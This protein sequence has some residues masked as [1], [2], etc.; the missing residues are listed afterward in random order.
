MIDF[1]K[2]LR[3]V[4]RRIDTRFPTK[5]DALAERQFP[6]RELG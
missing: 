1:F 3:E 6:D 4:R 5:P 2:R